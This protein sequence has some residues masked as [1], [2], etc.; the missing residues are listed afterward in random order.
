MKGV[1]SFEPLTRDLFNSYIEVG[2]KAY[3][4]H[5]LHLWPE[6]DSTPYL[7]R[8]FT[9]NVLLE[10][11]EN[12]NSDLFVIYVGTDPVGILKLIKNKGIE[13]FSATDALLLDKVYILKEH[14]GKGIGKVVMQFVVSFARSLM[15]KVVW[16]DT[17]KKGRALNFYLKNGF[18][19]L[20]ETRLS[21]ETAIEEEKGMYI[22]IKFI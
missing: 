4:Q 16:L 22:L 19:I 14:S 3:D 1:V 8:S 9:E 12:C 10:E 11:E 21:L 18:E 7:K 6:G 13:R 5:Y 20:K 17:M 2:T 15:K